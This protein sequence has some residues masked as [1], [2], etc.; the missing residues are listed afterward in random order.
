MIKAVLFDLDGTLFDRKTSLQR[1]VEDQYER[2][3]FLLAPLEKHDFRDLFVKFD[4]NGT[5]LK[6]Q[7]YKAICSRL[8]LKDLTW[9]LL[10]EE[11]ETQFSDHCIPHQGMQTMLDD[12]KESYKLAL[13]TNGQTTSQQR[14]ID[15]LGISDY[16]SPVLISAR[17]GVSKPDAEI[18]QRALW[19]L[20]ASPQE[21]I[22]VGDNPI[23]DI[24]GA[25]SAGMHTIWIRVGESGTCDSADRTVDEL[26]QIPGIVRSF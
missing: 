15:A 2:H 14:T 4:N 10:L 1:F 16:F 12:L 25:K 20:A 23:D 19:V 21:A 13:I 9:E 24:Q 5:V 3:Q 7:V 26:S 11:Y 18:F 6:E 8:E 17:E 22:F